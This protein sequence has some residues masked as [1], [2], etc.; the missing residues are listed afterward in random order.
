MLRPRPRGPNRHP[1]RHD[2]HR[3]QRPRPGLP[4]HRPVWHRHRTQ[5][6]Q[7]SL[8]I[9]TRT[10]TTPDGNG[11]P[12]GLVSRTV[13]DAKGQ[14]VWTTDRHLEG[15]TSDG[16]YNIYD[17]LGLAVEAR[18]YPNVQ[19]DIQM[20]TDGSLKAV[21]VSPD[22]DTTTPLSTNTTAYDNAGR[23]TSETNADGHT[24]NYEYDTA[25]RR[26]AVVDTVNGQTR[27]TDTSTTRRGGKFSSA[28]P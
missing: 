18:R 2:D 1:H 4:H 17:D 21:L 20:Q 22:P 24:T 8:V 13:D 16:T 5:V 3:L 23:V 9:E 6:R 11:N 14:A 10:Q 7:P 27:R 28:T 26:S 12:R 15:T 19:I 25:G